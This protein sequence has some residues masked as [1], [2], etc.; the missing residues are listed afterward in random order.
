MSILI[1]RAMLMMS[2]PI[3]QFYSVVGKNEDLYFDVYYISLMG[4]IIYSGL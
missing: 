2:E 1:L 3:Y 4:S